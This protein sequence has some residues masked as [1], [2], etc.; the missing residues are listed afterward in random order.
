MLLF[1]PDLVL[2]VRIPALPDRVGVATMAPAG[3]S[4]R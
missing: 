1:K 2:H 4:A 3:K